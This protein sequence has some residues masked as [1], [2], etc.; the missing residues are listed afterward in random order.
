MRLG[1]IPENLA[2]RVA[3]WFGIPPPGIIESWIGLMA[4]RAVLVATKLRVFEV[5]AAGPLTA[6]EIA[7]ILYSWPLWCTI[8]MTPPI[9]SSCNASL[10]RCNRAASSGSGSPCAKNAS[11]RSGNLAALWI[12]SS[13]SLAKLGQCGDF[14]DRE[15]DIAVVYEV[16]PPADSPKPGSWPTHS[17]PRRSTGSGGR[18]GSK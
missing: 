16:S 15:A 4:S 18:C 2:E 6:Q 13:D 8:S 9:G 3:M 11:V 7:T 14:D 5:L 12:S 1:I 17:P 10:G